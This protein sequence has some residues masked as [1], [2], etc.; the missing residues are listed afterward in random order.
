M[1]REGFRLKITIDKKKSNL[2]NLAPMLALSISKKTFSSEVLLDTESLLEDYNNDEN[3]LFLNIDSRIRYLQSRNVIDG[4][5]TSYDYYDDDEDKYKEADTIK[6]TEQFRI[7]QKT[8]TNTIFKKHTVRADAYNFTSS[9]NDMNFYLFKIYF[10]PKLT[11]NLPVEDKSEKKSIRNLYKKNS[12]NMFA[13][14]KGIDKS[15]FKSLKLNSAS[16]VTTKP[17]SDINGPIMTHLAGQN[18]QLILSTDTDQI[19]K[20]FTNNNQ[21]PN[22]K[23]LNSE[24]PNYSY[25]ILEKIKT[26]RE[27]LLTDKMVIQKTGFHCIQ[28]QFVFLIVILISLMAGDFA[29]NIILINY[30]NPLF[31]TLIAYSERRDYMTNLVSNTLWHMTVINSIEFPN[32]IPDY[33]ITN[34]NMLAIIE[35]D[36]QSLRGQQS[37]LEDQSVHI[38]EILTEYNAYILLKYV[39]YNKDRYPEISDIYLANAFENFFGD[40]VKYFFITNYTLENS[41]RIFYI[42]NPEGYLQTPYLR[43]SDLER[44]FIEILEN[45][46]SL[47]NRSDMNNFYLIDYFNN[48]HYEMKNVSVI[49]SGSSIFLTML[50][51][52]VIIT[53]F[54]K[55]F[56]AQDNILEILT[57]I[58]YP[59]GVKVIAICDKFLDLVNNNN[60]EQIGKYDKFYSKFITI[61]LLNL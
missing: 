55:L 22:D 2:F 5:A 33:N 36:I 50:F 25:S 6:S 49:L 17:K 4:Y 42:L 1:I 53:S 20:S 46:I 24:S 16:E 34:A 21:T 57:K 52:I 45:G 23:R 3:G 18:N 30:A 15:F 58:D 37:F 13:E 35:S 48:Y 11:T 61:A 14:D 51:C 39:N 10:I 41:D 12:L 56:K 44:R 31:N 28:T 7:L 8:I 59:C 29:N 54:M 40:I 9:H 19:S 26:F 32:T 60:N 47:I 43:M 38:K 27:T